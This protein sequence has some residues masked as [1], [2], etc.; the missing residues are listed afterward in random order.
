MDRNITYLVTALTLGAALEAHAA[1]PVLD[2]VQPPAE[3]ELPTA[4]YTGPLLTPNP[5][6]LP[7]GL[8]NIEP[9]LIS[10]Q[11]RDVYDAHGNHHRTTHSSQLTLVAPIT[12][13]ITDRI[14]GQLIPGMTH[15]RSGGLHTSG[16]RS[17][18]LSLTGQYLIQRP[19]ADG[20]RPAI[21]VA[22][23][24]GFPVGSHDRLGDNPL[25]GTGSGAS[26]DTLSLRMQQVI[27]TPSGR[28]FRWRANVA[29]GLTPN[30][31]NI[32]G[33]SVY[34]TSPGFRGKADLGDSWGA[35][36]AFEY[37]MT[38]HWVLA[39]DLAYN[40][41]AASRVH[42]TTPSLADGTRRSIDQRDGSSWVYSIAP[43]VEYNINGNVG[44]IAGVH[45]SVAGHNTSAFV[46]PQVAVNFVF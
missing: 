20:S 29:Y 6:N 32:H 38:P 5:A 23:T 26:R 25:N 11:V 1:E 10:N 9:Y 14:Q 16:F 12:Y 42:G 19:S 34:G 35:T 8:L 2:E 15:V 22:W 27:W 45:M 4:Y 37:S 30:A 39:M 41:Q 21:S 7:Q 24:H 33:S 18:D 40:W 36:W 46:S 17:T 44:I 31:V 3:T 43:A 13:G 28:P